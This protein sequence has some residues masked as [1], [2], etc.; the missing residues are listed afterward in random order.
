MTEQAPLD[1]FVIEPSQPELDRAADIIC[2]HDLIYRPDEETHNNFQF[3]QRVALRT[4]WEV[5]GEAYSIPE[6]LVS[7]SAADFPPRKINTATAAALVASRLIEIALT[8]P[9]GD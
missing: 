5:I 1:G 3:V 9:L 2:G 6:G 4:N 7:L 8:R